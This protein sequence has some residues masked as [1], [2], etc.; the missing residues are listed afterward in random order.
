MISETVLPI[1]KALESRGISVKY[2]DRDTQKPG[3]KFSEYE[4]KGVP[5]RITIG[6]R[7]IEQGTVEVARRDTLE[8][9]ILQITDID[10]KIEHLL[11]QIQKNL[12][13]R[14]LSFRENSTI[15]VDSYDEFKKVL[16]DKGGF[17]LAH[18]DGTAETEAKIKEETKATIRVIP[19]NNPQEE[20]KCIYTGKP[21][22][23]RV[24][25][26]RAY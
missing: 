6:P 10:I 8:K 4:F 17:I 20:G 23:Q 14:A 5:V 19:L 2:D 16:D 12:Y 1:K 7:D 11:D 18:W 25:F 13:D 3:W 15:R 26:A 21:S 22:H 24:I 9:D